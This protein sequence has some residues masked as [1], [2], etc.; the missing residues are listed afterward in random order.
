LIAG[1]SGFEPARYNEHDNGAKGL[2]PQQMIPPP[3]TLGPSGAPRKIGVEVE[4]SNI[5]CRSAADLVQK[6]FGGDV[7]EEDPYRF[8]VAA[9]ALGDFTVE[10]DMRHAHPHRKTQ[11][12]P[13]AF[14]GL[15]A[16]VRA[17]VGDLG[18]LWLPVEIVSPPVAW[19]RLPE[20]DAITQE[21]RRVGAHGTNDGLLYAFATQLNPE[22][23]SHDVKVILAY[24]KAF[25]VL[26]DRLRADA[27]RD[28][29]RRLLPFAAPMPRT[30]ARKVV[31]PA[32]QPSLEQL[33]DEYIEANPTRNRE[34]DMLPLFTA[35]DGEHV[36]R[37]IQSPLIK[38][39]PT[40]HYRLP[41]TRLSD[42]EWGLITEW[43]R[44]VQVEW[45]AADPERLDAACRHYC[46]CADEKRLDDWEDIVRQ[47]LGPLDKC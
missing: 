44:W 30:Y 35:L 19:E 15:E 42:P 46:A 28:I 36:G 27:A 37:Q 41:D 7:V 5:D 4:F 8:R 21:L 33:I 6:I 12:K 16:E 25:L 29:K 47:W 40:F 1:G 34:L 13:H 20:L 17:A 43:N 10:L 11:E 18:S 2:M 39:R 26:A 24:L 45:L 14:D 31:D 9:S 38:P 3:Y 32:Y 22:V 23:P